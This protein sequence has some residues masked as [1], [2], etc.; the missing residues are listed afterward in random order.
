MTRIGSDMLVTD[1]DEFVRKM[2]SVRTQY[3][4]AP[5]YGAFKLDGNHDNILSETNN[6]K[7]LELRNKLASGYMGNNNPTFESDIDGFIQSVIEQIN[8]KYISDQK[9]RPLD[10]SNIMMYM[11]VDVVSLLAMGKAIGFVPADKEI[12]EYVGT[13]WK[14]FPVLNFLSSYPPLVSFLSL[15]VVQRNTAP[16]VKEST[17]LGKI[18]AVAFEN[19]RQR[20]EMKNA[21]RDTQ[22]DMMESLLRTA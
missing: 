19:V 3:S 2:N 16:S 10:F 17:G 11:T 22:Q 8:T 20:I 18:K 21:Q 15:P 9:L 13:M 7:H 1:D 6:E 5:W 12:F 4:K 14:N